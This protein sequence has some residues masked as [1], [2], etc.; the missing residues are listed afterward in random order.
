MPFAR[1]NAPSISQRGPVNARSATPAAG[2]PGLVSCTY[3]HGRPSH[4]SCGTTIARVRKSRATLHAPSATSVTIFSA[5]QQPDARDSAIPS[6][7][8]ST[9]SSLLRGARTGSPYDASVASLADGTVDDFGAGSSPASTR[10]PPVGLA[11]NRFP[12]RNASPDRSTPGD[13]PYQMP[14]VPSY[15]DCRPGSGSCEP[16]TAVAASSSFTPGTSATSARSR[17]SGVDA[18]MRSTPPSGLPG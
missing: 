13:F 18:S 11:P 3:V 5:I 12:L 4:S 14:I 8:N 16:Q 6:K 1:T 15:G 10:T 9:I 7:P 2:G 17:S